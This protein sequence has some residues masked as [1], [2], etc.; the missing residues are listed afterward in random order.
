MTAPGPMMSLR[1]P[2]AAPRGALPR[3]H[4][5]CGS[6]PSPR[7]TLAARWTCGSTALMGWGRGLR[8]SLDERQLGLHAA[9]VE[10]RLRGLERGDHAQA[11]PAVADRRL[12]AAHAVD[13]VLGLEP[14]RL[15]ARDLG[16]HDVAGA[17]A[18]LELAE[19]GGV[20]EV[21]AVVE[22]LDPVSYTHLRA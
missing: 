16:R 4:G 3:M 8:A 1:S 10:R 22:D 18:Q 17:V 14:Q 13:E 20:L 21:D 15:G 7:V 5:G 6:Q 11:G 9:A 2:S 19:V 12:A